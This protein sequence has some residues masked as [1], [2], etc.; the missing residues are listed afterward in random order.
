MTF[1][2]SLI[3]KNGAETLKRLLPS[4]YHSNVFDQIV[5]VDTGSTDGTIDYVKSFPNIQLEHYKW[6]NNFAEARNYAHS[7]LTTDI[8]MWLDADDVATVKDFKAWKSLANKLYKSKD[9]AYVLPYNYSVNEFD[10]VI[11]KQF[12]ERIMKTPSNWTWKEPVHEICCHISSES[13]QKFLDASPVVHKPINDAERTTGRNWHILQKS[14]I[15]DRDTSPRTIYYLQKEAMGKGMFEYAITL[16]KLQ[17]E[18]NKESLAT[19]WLLY[20]SAKMQGEAYREL[21]FI[22]DEIEYYNRAKDVLSKITDHFPE[23]NEARA[24]LIELHLRNKEPLQ[25]L[26][27]V[28]ELRFDLPNTPA[29]VLT[30]KYTYFK[31]AIK[32]NI[33]MTAFSDYQTALT[34]HLTCVDAGFVSPLVFDNHK[35]LNSYTKNTPVTCVYYDNN[36]ITEAYTLINALQKQGIIRELLASSNT[37]VIN[38]AHDVYYHVTASED[39]LYKDESPA[40]TNKILVK[41]NG[42]VMSNL[43]GYKDY[44]QVETIN[45]D[46]VTALVDQITSNVYETNIIESLTQFIREAKYTNKK[47]I[48][49]IISAED[50]SSISDTEFPAVEQSFSAKIFLNKDKQVVAMYGPTEIFQRFGVEENAL[51]IKEEQYKNVEFIEADTA[52][53]GIPF[54]IKL[55]S[56]TDKSIA[57]YAGGIENWDG[58]S[59]YRDGIGGS[60][61]SVVYLAEQLGN[62]GHNVYVYSPNIEY[63]YINNVYYVPM[64]AFDED[65]TFD[66]FISSRIPTILNKRR[67]K[68]QCLW[69]HDTMD[70]YMRRFNQDQII[71]KYIC[72]SNWQKA[73]A[74]A[75]GILSHKIEVIA[76]GV[77]T[78]NGFATY[79]RVK[80]SCVW[81]S[82]PDRGLDNLLAINDV[83][84]IAKDMHILYSWHNINVINADNY[85]IYNRTIKEKNK[86]KGLNAKLIGRVPID[87]VKQ[88]LHSTEKLIYPSSF[89]ETFCISVVE[90]L[91]AGV[92][93]FVNRNGA[94]HDTIMQSTC[95][96]HANWFLPT[97]KEDYTPK[98]AKAWIKSVNENNPEPKEQCLRKGVTWEE[99]ANRW[100][101]VIDV[102][103]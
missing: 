28:E 42:A 55:V 75:I 33:L 73:T 38:F 25:A 27:V 19:D 53:T 40:K 56:D 18:Y 100:I 101:E 11:L 52:A 94:V 66:V 81:M 3:V 30:D 36:L 59:P 76:N 17:Q 93:C 15:V 71:D 35:L 4:L 84:P 46:N 90:A 85:F 44:H 23:F 82:S 99:L 29:A 39:T 96:K 21:Y 24:S 103:V 83:E 88:V 86:L 87:E 26:N 50:G 70:A 20:E 5:I 37:G 48:A 72:V 69:M 58:L 14:F 32:A 79:D 95:K 16:G 47:W 65:K 13:R 2:I 22:T 60:E 43:Y 80:N 49:A 67:A 6:T 34:H 10:E 31:D 68:K 89:K 102:Q 78:Y 51:L 92:T 41:L 54:Q 1:G 45:D 63:R 61:S 91:Y 12:R 62:K 74:E 64:S 98:D 9:D 7:F 8:F 77:H 97:G 57:F